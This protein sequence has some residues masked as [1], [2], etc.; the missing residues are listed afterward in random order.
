MCKFWIVFQKAQ[1]LE[2]EYNVKQNK[3]ICTGIAKYCILYNIIWKQNS[4]L[5]NLLWFLHP[6]ETFLHVR[7]QSA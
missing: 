2:M 4:M 5:I 7:P 6:K 1:V 3:I